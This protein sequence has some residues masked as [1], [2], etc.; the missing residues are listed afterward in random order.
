MITVSFPA[1]SRSETQGREEIGAVM[2]SDVMEAE[3]GIDGGID[4]RIRIGIGAESVL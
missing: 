3:V 1:S 2:V 4:H